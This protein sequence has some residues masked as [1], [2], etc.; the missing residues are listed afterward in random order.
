[1]AVSSYVNWKCFV[2]CGLL[3]V[4]AQRVLAQAVVDWVPLTLQESKQPVVYFTLPHAVRRDTIQTPLGEIPVQTFYARDLQGVSG[5]RLYSLMMYDYPEGSFP[6]DS[7]ARIEEFFDATLQAAVTSVQGELKFVDDLGKRYPSKVFRVD[8]GEQGNVTRNH[9]Y[10]VGDRY[11][12]QQVMSAKS[13]D[14]SK[15]RARFFDSFQ[16]I[17]PR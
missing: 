4:G 10:L 1:M 8:F 13:D 11:Y 6:P 3:I 7:I 15:S 12:H 2:L 14:G 16:P 9:A 5:N 17:H